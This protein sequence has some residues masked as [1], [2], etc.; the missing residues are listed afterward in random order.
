M[1]NCKEKTVKGGYKAMLRDRMLLTTNLAL[2]RCECKNAYIDYVYDRFVRCV[3]VE[4]RKNAVK[5]VLGLKVAMSSELIRVLLYKNNIKITSEQAANIPNQLRFY[6][7]R[8]TIGWEELKKNN[9]KLYERFKIAASW[10]DWFRV[11]FQDVE[12][13]YIIGKKTGKSDE[14][15]RLS[16]ADRYRI[17]DDTITFLFKYFKR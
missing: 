15:I 4:L 2:K 5:E 10:V 11:R 16:I 8:D 12:N 1:E 3:P 17:D 7:F 14:Q 13:T 6:Q 9:P